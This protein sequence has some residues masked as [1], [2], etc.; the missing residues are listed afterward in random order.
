MYV[1]PYLVYDCDLR[2]QSF[3]TN[4]P[5][6]VYHFTIFSP[7]FIYFKRNIIFISNYNASKMFTRME[8]NLPIQ[9]T[10]LFDNIMSQVLAE[11]FHKSQGKSCTEI[12]TRRVISFTIP[13]PN[14]NNRS[15]GL[16]YIPNDANIVWRNLRTDS[17]MLRNF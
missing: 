5:T 12:M 7:Q 10:I 6:S 13:R 9:I 1:S 15:N 14:K 16:L 8:P 17:R 4:S 3:R 11:L 2:T